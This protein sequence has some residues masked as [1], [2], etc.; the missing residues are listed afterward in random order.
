MIYKLRRRRRNMSHQSVETTASTTTTTTMTTTTIP[1]I[2]TYQNMSIDA[3]E[4]LKNEYF[5]SASRWNLAMIKTCIDRGIPV[6]IR[7]ENGWNV[8]HL[9]M[10]GFRAIDERKQFCCCCIEIIKYLVYECSMDINSVRINEGSSIL[11]LALS[12]SG[13]FEVAKFLIY[14]CSTMINVHL[15][16]IVK[17]NALHILLS[18]RRDSHFDIQDEDGYYDMIKH[19]IEERNINIYANNSEGQNALHYACRNGHIDVVKYLIEECHM[20]NLQQQDNHGCTALHD[21]VCYNQ[22]EI[23]Q[24]LINNRCIDINLCDYHL[25]HN[26]LHYSLKGG[27]KY[28]IVQCLIDDGNA[29]L[30]STSKYGENVFHI[31]FNNH[32]IRYDIDIVVLLVTRLLAK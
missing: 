11:H 27:P 4:A 14:D 3:Q 25:R 26:A 5:V 21:A 24:Y 23:V 22:Y 17:N 31:L 18:S 15:Q 16:N 12:R 7:D 10:F 2:I 8:L 20:N 9:L 19:L 30:T 32:T 6:G 13:E 28:K 1:T 29:D